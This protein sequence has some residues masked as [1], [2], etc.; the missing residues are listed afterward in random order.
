MNTTAIPAEL[1][2]DLEEFAPAF[3]RVADLLSA[4]RIPSLFDRTL[5]LSEMIEF[6]ACYYSIKWTT[7]AEV[8]FIR[9][10]DAAFNRI[11]DRHPGLSRMVVL[12]NP[13]PFTYE[14]QPFSV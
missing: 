3:R 1:I 10:A 5:N 6:G 12:D 11:V 8:S 2:H 13:Q 4:A 14:G 9:V 7:D